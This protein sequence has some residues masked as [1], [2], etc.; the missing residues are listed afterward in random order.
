MTTLLL[1]CAGRSSRYPGVRPKWMLTTPE[2]RLAV[3]VAAAS[4][5]A[6]I[7]TR[8]V[9]AIRADHDAAFGGGSALRRAFGDDI[10]ILVLD[11][12]TNGP[13]HTV[14]TMIEKAGV[15]GP[16]LIK[17]ADSFFVPAP[18]MKKNFVA[19]VDL[20]QALDMSRVGA[21][22]FVTL[23][24]HGLIAG[25]T[26]KEVVSNYISCGL[27]GF[28]DAAEFLRCFKTVRDLA[29]GETF[30]SHIISEGLGRGDAVWPHFVND[31]V[32]VGTLDDWRAYTATRRVYFC[33]IDGVVFK[34]QSAFFPPFWGDDPEPITENIAH[35]KKLTSDGGQLIF[36]T[37]RSEAYREATLRALDSVGLKAHALVMGCAH[38]ARVM[39][40]DFADSNPYPTA[41]AINIAR[42]QPDLARLLS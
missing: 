31:F 21:K 11:R 4:V 12:E 36:V 14:A 19:V 8:R 23:N 1:P 40:N 5:P 42:N 10:E 30:V 27:Y 37:S 24:E 28:T 26:E 17:D 34:N 16:I 39:I 29:L 20:R 22:S 38:A 33:D 32:D 3:E 18:I 15:K 13:A 25:I 9:I 6:G 7:V 2:G 35:L 41:S